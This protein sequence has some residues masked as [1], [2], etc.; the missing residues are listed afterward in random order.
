[1]CKFLD[2]FLS[3]FDGLSRVDS[4][5]LRFKRQNCEPIKKCFSLLSQRIVA[6]SFEFLMHM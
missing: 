2:V 6:N 5:C 3:I 4:F 1:M